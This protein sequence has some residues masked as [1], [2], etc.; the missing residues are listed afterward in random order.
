MT[1]GKGPRHNW[2]WGTVVLVIGFAFPLAGA[3]LGAV[4]ARTDW[5]AAV[6][7]AAAAVALALAVLAIRARR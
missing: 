5:G 4:N 3:V 6:L 2:G 7:S 1:R